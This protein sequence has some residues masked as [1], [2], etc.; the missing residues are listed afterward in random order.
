M[1]VLHIITTLGEG[2]AQG[3]LTRICCY[4]NPSISHYIISL[5][6]ADTHSEK[7]ISNN[8]S[9]LKLGIGEGFWQTIHSFF[10]LYKLINQ[11]NP[12]VIQTWMYYGDFFGGLAA[13]LAAKKNIIWSVRHCSIDHNTKIKT[14]LVIKILSYM[15][16]F[17]PKKI[18]FNS[19]KSSLE[20]IKY[21]YSQKKIIVIPNGFETTSFEKLSDKCYEFRNS[22]GISENQKLIGMVA[23]YHPDKDHKTL[24]LTIKQVK[25]YFPK[26]ICLLVGENMDYNNYNLTS[27]INHLNLEE[28]VKL[29]GVRRDIS[30]IMKCLDIHLLTSSSEAFPNVI[31]EAM[32]NGVPCIS[33]NVG[34]A[35]F[36]IGKT[37]W[38]LNVGDVNSLSLRTI[39]ALNASDDPLWKE[40]KIEAFKR[41]EEYF[42][43]DKMISSFL[44]VWC[45]P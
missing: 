16:Y 25:N 8:C 33:T 13:W 30:M 21:G 9:V 37:G 20:H 6:Q 42:S 19:R 3:V 17:V 23:R 29:L 12:D 10:K 4:D 28:N 45:N 41:I 14:R 27:L 35:S 11:I 38:I 26:I 36:L 22:L 40:R 2:G 39:E 44:K 31:G 24:L 43:I 18:I 1:R 32:A 15:S 5:K 34:D 7:L